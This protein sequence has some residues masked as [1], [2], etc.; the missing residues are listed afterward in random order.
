VI[1]LPGG[2]RLP[3]YLD[4]IP[5]TIGWLEGPPQGRGLE[6]Q[7]RAV[8]LARAA[9]TFFG[10]NPRFRAFRCSTCQRVEFAYDKPVYDPR[11][12]L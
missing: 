12:D 5:T 4:N 6:D 10:R 8:P 7:G 11:S 2:A 3:L 9:L 1:G